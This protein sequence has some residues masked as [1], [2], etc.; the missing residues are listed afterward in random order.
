MKKLR[1]RAVKDLVKQVISETKKAASHQEIR[2]LQSCMASQIII[3]S[4]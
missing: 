2:N 4:V 3:E 1:D